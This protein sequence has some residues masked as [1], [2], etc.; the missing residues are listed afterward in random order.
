MTPLRPMVSQRRCA[1]HKQAL[2]TCTPRLHLAVGT[3]MLLWPKGLRD[4]NGTQAKSLH[5][6][7]IHRGAIAIR[8]QRPRGRPRSRWGGGQLQ[9]PPPPPPRRVAADTSRCSSPAS[10]AAQARRGRA[11]PPVR[12]SA[13]H[14]RARGQCST[15]PLH[16]TRTCAS[17]L[18]AEAWPQP[19]CRAAEP[20]V[21]GF[22]HLATRAAAGMCCART[23]SSACA[24]LAPATCCPAPLGWVRTCA[25]LIRLEVA[26]CAC[27]EQQRHRPELPQLHL[28]L[29]FARH[30]VQQRRR[31][32]DDAIGVRR[33]RPCALV[34]G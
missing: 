18:T 19:T 16:S 21:S 1:L 10:S 2:H 23:R 34:R 13:R 14:C 5:N 15:A 26:R 20:L 12:S 30:Y 31:V 7:T 3:R 22:G 27:P 25:A 6:R 17:L 4:S 9:A 28:A 11:A 29:I 8:Q 32:A 24:L 33:Q